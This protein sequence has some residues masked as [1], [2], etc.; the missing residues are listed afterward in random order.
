MNLVRGRIE[1]N[2]SGLVCRLGDQ[3]LP[4]PSDVA[5]YARFVDREVAIGVRPEHLHVDR[6]DLPTVSVAV[7]L[8][9]TLGPE[10]LL[11]V[12]LAADPVLTED[13]LDVARDV[14]ATAMAELQHEASGREVRL[15]SRVDPRHRFTSGE[16]LDVGVAADALHLFDL[17][18]GQ[19]I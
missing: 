5:R 8:T 1:R 4:L 6:D 7:T 16:R 9:E 10:G 3:T 15:V 12:T 19:A 17:K 14:D 11:H 18:S 13:V 2:G